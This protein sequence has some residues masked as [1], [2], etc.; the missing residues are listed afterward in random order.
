MI[1]FIA[2]FWGHS[3]FVLFRIVFYYS[4]LFFY[5]FT[6]YCYTL[7]MLYILYSLFHV[8][9]IIIII[10]FMDITQPAKSQ[11]MC[12]KVL[13]S[14]HLVQQHRVGEGSQL[15]CLHVQ[16]RQRLTA[17]GISTGCSDGGGV[18]AMTVHG[19]TQPKLAA[20]MGEL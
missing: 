15:I 19:A 3:C 18:S 16:L 14:T 12:V 6:Y 10:F 2:G 4:L 1:G 13:A 17:V 11:G 5:Y 7:Y 9:L 8:I 20:A